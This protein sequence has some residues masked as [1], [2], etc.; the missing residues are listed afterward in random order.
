M[1]STTVGFNTN[2]FIPYDQF[3]GKYGYSNEIIPLVESGFISIIHL[4]IKMEI[5]LEI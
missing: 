3:N 5:I 2:S 4:F 1:G